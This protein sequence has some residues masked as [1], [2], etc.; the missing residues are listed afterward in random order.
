[1]KTNLLMTTALLASGS[2]TML[3]LSL[4]LPKLS[5]GLIPVAT[6]LGGASIALVLV[7]DENDRAT[8]P[9][10][11]TTD[12]PPSSFPDRQTPLPSTP[13]SS[14][15]TPAIF[16]QPP[17]P[18]ELKSGTLIFVGGQGSGKSTSAVMVLHDRVSEGSRGIVLNHHAPYGAYEGLEVYGRGESFEDR[19][20]SLETGMQLIIGEIE[21]RY[22]RLQT[23]P[24]PSF[25]PISVLMEEM[26][27]WRGN[28]DK[29][30]LAK[31][32][33]L[34]LTDT[35]KA[36]IQ[37]IWVAHNLT[38]E[39]WGGID[40]IANLVKNSGTIIYLDA[41]PD[42]N[43]GMKSSGYGDVESNGQKRRVKLSGYLPNISGNLWDFTCY[44]A[45]RHHRVSTLENA[46]NLPATEKLLPDV[47]GK[48]R[49]FLAS[50]SP[51]KVRDIQRHKD[52]RHLSADEIREILGAMAADDLIAFDGNQAVLV[53]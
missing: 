46:F 11:I 45:P 43:G 31:F 12:Y 22:H 39:C 30:L 40:G 35:R 33:K 1:M 17:T 21:R 27:S 2:V 24:N 29:D 37:T 9:T 18:P 47:W 23:E 48:M 10:A 15:G 25:S 28:I 4:A 36:N 49:V 51:A 14:H 8:Y 5:K 44:G 53:I 20:L 26:S 3:A 52:F 42:G 16:G 50:N 34:T 38:R 32:I 41:V 7:G 13:P 19:F 6:A